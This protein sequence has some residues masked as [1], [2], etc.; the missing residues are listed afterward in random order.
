MPK[1]SWGSEFIYI[2]DEGSIEIISLAADRKE[3]GKDESA[4]IKMSECK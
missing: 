4:D 2:N 3:G 1:D